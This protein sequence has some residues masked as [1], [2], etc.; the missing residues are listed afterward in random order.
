MTAIAV[1]LFIF[2]WFLPHWVDQRANGL[3]P[4]VSEATNGPIPD[5]HGRLQIVDLH[6]DT[7]LWDRDLL[8]WGQRGHV[9]LPRLQQGNFTLQVF[10]VV[11]KAP[12]TINY[13]QNSANS[14]NIT[15][16]AMAERWPLSTWESLSE[17]A[18]YQAHR[19]QSFIADSK[20]QLR[21]V[22][23]QSELQKLVDDRKKDHELVGALLAI[24]G[25]QALEGDLAKLETLYH[26]GFRVISPAHLADTELSGSQQGV[27][28]AG[29]SDLG[30]Q[31]VLQMNRLQMII[32]VAHVSNQAIDE[33][34]QLSSRPL[35]VSHTG[36]RS[37]CDS[38][39]NLSDDQVRRIAQAGGIIGIGFWPEVNCGQG[40][41][42]IVK[43]LRRAIEVAGVDH[44]ALGSD[45]DGFVSTAIDASGVGFLTGSLLKQSF[46]EEE[47]R[48]LMGE[49][50]IRFLMANLQVTSK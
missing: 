13:Q 18:L 12:R 21:L 7:L 10:S 16:L 15:L 27:S 26:E 31:W 46:T 5:L 11:T 38:N 39:R 17:R 22:R 49:N 50:A 28:K 25:G 48:K 23:D 9:D 37:V 30:R 35:M 3:G 32:D 34:L 47:V 33:I 14:D 1:A 20:G 4:K 6:A 29:L 43:S 45:W 8:K 42:P 44:V 19:M 41:D 2:F 36:L 24:E 40:I